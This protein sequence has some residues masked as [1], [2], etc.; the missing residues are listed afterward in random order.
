MAA[1]CHEG[2][3]VVHSQIA[4]HVAIAWCAWAVLKLWICCSVL[5]PSCCHSE[6]PCTAMQGMHG[7]HSVIGIKLHMCLGPKC[8]WHRALC[9]ACDDQACLA[10]VAV[11]VV[12][13]ATAPT[14]AGTCAPLPRRAPTLCFS[15][16]LFGSRQSRHPL[17]PTTV[18]P[19]LVMIIPLR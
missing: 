7:S 18:L 12:P 17:A 1:S 3:L 14:L 6:L 2:L 16:L 10:F 9:H 11:K 19:S 15:C 8:G 5:G 4:F 13:M